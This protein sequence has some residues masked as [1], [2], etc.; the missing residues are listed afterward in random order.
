MFFWLQQKC[1]L[2][3]LWRCVCV[4]HIHTPTSYLLVAQGLAWC[5][6]RGRGVQKAMLSIAIK[7]M[8]PRPILSAGNVQLCHVW[9]HPLTVQALL[10]LLLFIYFGCAGYLLLC[11][12]FLW[13]PRAG[14][15]PSLRCTSFS[16]Q[17]LLSL[18]STGSRHKGFSS[19]SVWAQ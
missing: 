2:L 17:R 3:L 8:N 10:L 5:L 4:T 19:C 14:G 1:L 6:L 13:L 7:I 18:Q 16:L 11:T 12:G 15:C 9:G